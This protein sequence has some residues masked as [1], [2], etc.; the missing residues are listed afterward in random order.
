MAAAI[1]M[2]DAE[3]MLAFLDAEAEASAPPTMQEV[4]TA[5]GFKSK[6]AMWRRLQLL[7]LR[8]WLRRRSEST[9]PRNLI[10]TRKG[11]Q[12]ARDF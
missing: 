3:V 8:G 1:D 5:A 7:E 9:S 11:R 10:A 4:A 6:S 12:G 2:S